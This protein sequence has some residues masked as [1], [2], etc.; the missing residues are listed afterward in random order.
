MPIGRCV[1][2]EDNP[3]PHASGKLSVPVSRRRALRSVLSLI[4]LLLLLLMTMMMMMM[5]III[6]IILM[7]VLIINIININERIS[8][9]PF[10]AKHARLH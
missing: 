4:L 9:A 6:I 7:S 10:H 8:G 5:M 1:H 3:R 2:G